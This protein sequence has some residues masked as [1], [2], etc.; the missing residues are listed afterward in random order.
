MYPEQMGR[1][2]AA[3]RLRVRRSFPYRKGFVALDPRVSVAGDR[4]ART[5]REGTPVW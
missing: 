2:G 1:A 4:Q 5:R 3:G